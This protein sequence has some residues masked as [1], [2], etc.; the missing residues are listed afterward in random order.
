MSSKTKFSNIIETV[1]QRKFYCQ[2]YHLKELLDSAVTDISAADQS[3]DYSYLE[4]AREKANEIYLALTGEHVARTKPAK[5]RKEPKIGSKDWED[6][7]EEDSD[8]EEEP[9]EVRLSRIEEMLAGLLKREHEKKP[10]ANKK[11]KRL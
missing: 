8:E 5:E 4:C 1:D 2:I 6:E 11:T 10:K 7:E 9:V 3:G